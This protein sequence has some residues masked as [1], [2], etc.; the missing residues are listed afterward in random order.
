[1][2]GLGRVRKVKNRTRRQG[3]AVCATPAWVCG[4][5]LIKWGAQLLT[6]TGQWGPYL[7]VVA[8]TKSRFLQQP[9]D[10]SGRHFLE[11]LGHPG[12]TALSC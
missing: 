1:M 3:E 8:G 12:D 9:C 6:E 5:A 10:L 4:L 2:Q 7:L 11:E